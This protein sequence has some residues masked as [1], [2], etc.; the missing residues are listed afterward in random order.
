M[1]S[2]QGIH[3][4]SP[5]NPDITFR[6]N[7]EAFGSCQERTRDEKS[8]E[9]K[10]KDHAVFTFSSFFLSVV[11]KRLENKHLFLVRVLILLSDVGL[12]GATLNI[13]LLQI[14]QGPSGQ[15]ARRAG[16]V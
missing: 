3:R 7:I 11:P 6:S 8:A 12:D 9:R 4:I 15:R 16:Q 1:V 14:R 13:R 5:T 2:S 10:C